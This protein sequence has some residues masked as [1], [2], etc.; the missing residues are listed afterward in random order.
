MTSAADPPRVSLFKTSTAAVLRALRR[1]PVSTV[2]GAELDRYVSA[3]SSKDLAIE[4][5]RMVLKYEQ[6]GVTITPSE[7]ILLA[8]EYLRAL[9]L[10]ERV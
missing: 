7:T 3:R 6:A 9:H 8:R 1:A 2:S 4:V 10:K 5:A